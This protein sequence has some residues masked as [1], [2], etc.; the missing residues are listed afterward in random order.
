MPKAP[1]ST[2]PVFLTCSDIA[3]ELGLNHVTIWRAIRR[4]SLSPISRSKGGYCFY[5]L[6]QI[7]EIKAHL[8]SLH[9]KR[10]SA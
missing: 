2:P 9:P 6:E 4:M 7:D 1:A 10:T 8:A 3:V 5:S